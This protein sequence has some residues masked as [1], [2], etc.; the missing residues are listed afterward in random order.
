MQQVAMLQPGDM[1][2]L[3][4]PAG[5]AAHRRKKID[6]AVKAVESLGFRV[7]VGQSCYEKW[8]YLAGSDDVRAHDLNAF[9]ANPEIAGIF[10]MRG[11][12]GSIRLLD[13]LD[14]DAIARHPKVFVG[15]S[16]ITALHL[17][18]NQ[19]AGFITFHGPMPV[20]DFIRPGF[21]DYAKQRLLQA[22]MSPEPLGAIPSPPEAP[23]IEAVSPGDAE[24][25]LVGGN[26]ANICALMGTP[27][28]IDTRGKILLL[29]DIYEEAY[30]IDRMLTQLRLGGKF[31]DAAGIVIGDFTHWEPTEEHNYLPLDDVIK[32]ILLPLNTPILKNVCF[33]HGRFNAT[34]P[35]GAMARIDG[36]Q[37][38]LIVTESGVQRSSFERC[39]FINTSPVSE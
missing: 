36:S 18:L 19:K 13:R 21:D 33:G 35:L 15:Y 24:G 17:A 8:G 4:A 10:C 7:I 3:P 38:S 1:I 12:Y 26:L 34:L 27:F 30:R 14:F 23:A 20:S 29:E 5:P 2:G 39:F 22:I 9:F 32:N 6:L 16:D 11:G 25:R 28:E 37:G 31:T